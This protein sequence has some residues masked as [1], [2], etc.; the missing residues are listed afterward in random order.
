MAMASQLKIGGFHGM[1]RPF[2]QTGLSV[3]AEF[4][5]VDSSFERIVAELLVKQGR[6]FTKQL[7]YDAG[8]EQVLPDFILTDTAKEVPLEVFGRDDADYL[9]RQEEKAAYYNAQY[10]RAGWW[11][12]DALA[13]SSPS[14]VPP[15][16]PAR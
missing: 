5:P 7:R 14:D 13:S 4:V 2:M 16:P 8:T 3:T 9:K 6:S 11:S 10:G 1:P 15:F 12:W